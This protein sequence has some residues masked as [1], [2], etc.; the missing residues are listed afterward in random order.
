MNV[1][2]PTSGIFGVDLTADII[3]IAACPKVWFVLRFKCDV[4]E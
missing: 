4:S 3:I 2:Q 1:L